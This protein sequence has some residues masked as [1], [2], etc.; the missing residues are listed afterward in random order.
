MGREIERRFFVKEGFRPWQLTD[1]KILIHQTYL[2]GTGDWALRGRLS[3]N[4]KTDAVEYTI[5]L[6]QGISDIESKE[7]NISTDA[8]G[9]FD[10][11]SECL[12]PLMKTRYL[13]PHGDL[14]FEVDMFGGP[15]ADRPF[16]AEIEL[17]S[18]DHPLTLPDWV[19]EEITGR[20]G[21][22]NFAIFR[23]M[24]GIKKK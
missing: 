16:V 2:M 9:Y 7:I 20:K 11:V 21:H 6:K 22:S 18:A 19:G 23:K 12:P 4:V 24:H 1:D 13:I 15:I 8:R 14:T 5:T 3:R 10:F 17:P